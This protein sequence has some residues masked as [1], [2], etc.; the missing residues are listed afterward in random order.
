M[1]NTDNNIRAFESLE[2]HDDDIHKLSVLYIEMVYD[3][4]R[5]RA[6]QLVVMVETVQTRS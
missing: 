4:E 5:E 2:H 3:L 1:F 6:H